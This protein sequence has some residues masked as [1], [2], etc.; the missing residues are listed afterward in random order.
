MLLWCRGL[1]LLGVWP[2]KSINT[3]KSTYVN[4]SRE[5]DH[6]IFSSIVKYAEYPLMGR[7]NVQ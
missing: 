1:H 6:L 4:T 7:T 5:K 3:S 2:Y